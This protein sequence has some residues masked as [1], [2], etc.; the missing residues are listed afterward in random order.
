M[1]RFQSGHYVEQVA[2]RPGKP[3]K[4]CHSDRIILAHE[5]DES[6]KLLPPAHCRYLLE[7]Y[8]LA[9]GCQEVSLLSLNP[10]VLIY[11]RCTCITNQHGISV[12]LELC[13][14]DTTGLESV[15]R[16]V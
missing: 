6:I 1:L 10:G 4:A 13:R 14:N 16:F 5:I 11:G 9:S 7:E 15:Y 8:L 3:I 2:H 12:L